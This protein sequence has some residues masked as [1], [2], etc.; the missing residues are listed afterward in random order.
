MP[1]HEPHKIKTV[2]LLAFPTPEERK[3]HLADVRFNVFHLTP[4][5]VTFDMC[6]NAINAV[7]Q[8]QLAGQ[9]IGD[10][11]YAGAR[12]FEN[13][14]KA[15]QSVLGHHYVCP[16]HNGLGA[17]K[18]VMA[19]LVQPGTVLPS[20]ARS[21]AGVFALRDVDVPDMRDHMAPVFT[22]NMSLGLLRTTLEE[23]NV[24][25]VGLQMF[26]DGQHPVSLENL[27]AI[28]ALAH[29]FGKH[30][31]CDG[32]RVIENAWYIQRHEP[33][34]ADRPIAR[35]VKEIARTTDIFYVDGAQDPKCNT[36]GILTTS[37]P[38]LH[39][40]FMN[41]VVVYEGLHTYGGMAGRTMEVL[42]RGLMEMAE[43]DE[44]QWTMA[45]IERFTDRL[46]AG[47]VP[48][49][50]GC[51]GAYIDTSS[52]LSHINNHHQDAFSAALYEIAGVRAFAAGLVRPDRLVPVQI[53]RLA[54]M[55]EQVDQVADAIVSLF[56]QRDKVPALNAVEEGRWRD[57]MAY[58][59][60][61]ADLE[62]FTFHTAPYEVH[63]IEK[64]GVLSRERREAAI[65]EAG[66]NT[67][68]LRSADVAIDLLTDSGTSAMSTDQ[69][70][71][72]DGA[73]ASASTSD[74]YHDLV[75]A[76]KDITGYKHIIPT[77][78]G[79]AA[80]HPA[81]C[82]SRRPSS[83]RSSRAARSPT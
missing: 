23:R 78:Q 14:R 34:Y 3:K 55:N 53:P 70:A 7:S 10:E 31:L 25:L 42:A 29:E 57:Q 26:A 38:E 73:R 54:M 19:T 81:T 39:E 20:N 66:Y 76:L 9:F 15:V 36:G 12:N 27:R 18:L 47:G 6:S 40:Q 61:F 67:F 2:R 79:R 51:D 35:I 17:L 37:K 41:E 52:F 74:A 30:V 32:S 22:G 59:G 68:L 44:V 72:Y 60:V 49:E 1:V 69:W 46:R 43:E 56:E 24:P 65:K 33:G 48:L 5:Q 50:R 21:R 11:A 62:P 8:E 63:T 64:V 71:A 4:S 28:R 75:A 58:H 13:L 16:V 83:T 77:H 82:T 45:Q 80:E